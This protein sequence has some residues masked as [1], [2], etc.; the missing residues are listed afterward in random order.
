MNPPYPILNYGNYGTIN[1][2]ISAITLF[3]NTSIV[4]W[5]FLAPWM[6]GPV[7]GYFRMVGRVLH[8]GTKMSDLGGWLSDLLHICRIT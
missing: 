8:M 4:E 6:H 5:P 2:G 1:I 7:Y 3:G